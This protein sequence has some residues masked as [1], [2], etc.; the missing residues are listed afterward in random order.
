M[1]GIEQYNMGQQQQET[2]PPQAMAQQAPVA[3]TE[4]QIQQEQQEQQIPEYE[5][6]P[7]LENEKASKAIAT[8]MKNEKMLNLLRLQGAQELTAEQ[9]KINKMRTGM[10]MARQYGQQ[11]GAQAML[12][13][14][15]P[16][17]GQTRYIANGLR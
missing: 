9:D 3:A 7:V 4:Q 10:E 15:V 1:M 14:N 12:N 13:W 5:P 6:N 17:L 2:M 11:E 8:A 16:Q